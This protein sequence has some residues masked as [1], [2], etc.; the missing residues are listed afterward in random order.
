MPKIKMCECGCGLVVKNRFRRGHQIRVKNPSSGLFGQN[1]KSW[2]GGR[3]CND[4][5]YWM[6][7]IPDHPRSTSNG[8]VREHIA[9]AERALGKPL[10]EKAQIHHYGC[11]TNNNKIVIC[12]NQ[13]YHR[14][15]EMRQDAL[16]YSGKA[17]NRKCKFCQRYDSPENL[18]ITQSPPH[19]WNIHHQSCESIY[20]RDRTE[21]GRSC[22]Y[23]ITNRG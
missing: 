14:L 19:G 3:Y 12:E 15:I 13:E 21:R 9:M 11:V 17:R 18:H 8:Y 23:E 5:G 6:I 16:K 10:P 7:L 22:H 1:S 4:Q 20:E 2:K